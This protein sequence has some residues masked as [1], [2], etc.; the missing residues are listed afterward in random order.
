VLA[1]G[2]II[3]GGCA[4]GWF[5]LF[6][7]LPKGSSGRL[8]KG[9]WLFAGIAVLYGICETSFGNWGIL[10]LQTERNISGELSSL[11]LSLFWGAV[12]VGR[13]LSAC[14]T[15]KIPARMIYGSIGFLFIG[16]LALLNYSPFVLPSFFLAGLGC[17]AFLPLSVSLSQS[18]DLPHA[19]LISGMI[20]ALYMF[21]YGITAFGVGWL[22]AASSFSLNNLFLLLFIPAIVMTFL[23]LFSRS[24][25]Q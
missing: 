6:L 13:I 20:I 7:N 21:G 2:Y 4:W 3:L 11:S 22:E 1:A 17:S 5:P 25:Y 19:E 10:Y 14:L 16:A 15:I 23:T 8:K 24:R 12:T 9:V 18:Q